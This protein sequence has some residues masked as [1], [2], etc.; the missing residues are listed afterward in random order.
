[1]NHVSVEECVGG[2]QIYYAEV[3]DVRLLLRKVERVKGTEL[4][5]T[6]VAEVCAT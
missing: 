1:M 4:E 2:V 6:S 5:E 3:K